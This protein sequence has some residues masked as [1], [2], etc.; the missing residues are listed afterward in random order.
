VSF[1][2]SFLPALIVLFVFFFVRLFSKEDIGSYRAISTVWVWTHSAHA[3]WY[4]V[5]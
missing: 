5:P 2:P 4:A 1:V 3:Q